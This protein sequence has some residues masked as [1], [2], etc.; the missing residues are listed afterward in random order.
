ML[1]VTA[2]TSVGHFDSAEYAAKGVEQVIA[3][4]G[5]RDPTVFQV[6]YLLRS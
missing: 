1:D 3:S 5:V 2:R 4:H 6:E